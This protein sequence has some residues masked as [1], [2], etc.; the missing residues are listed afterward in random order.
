MVEEQQQVNRNQQPIR[1]RLSSS[2]LRWRL[3]GTS[4][5]PCRPRDNSR[6]LLHSL[7]N[8]PRLHHSP[9]TFSTSWLEDSL[10]LSLDLFHHRLALLLQ[11]LLLQHLLLLRE[12]Q[13]ALLLQVGRKEAPP[14]HPLQEAAGPPSCSPPFPSSPISP[15]P[16]HLLTSLVSPTLSSASWRA[17]SGVTLRPGSSASETS[18]SCWTRP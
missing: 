13:L 16:Y 3:S 4:W 1:Q 2:R 14:P 11:H 15:L 9:P 12:L 7:N 6:H 17:R 5:R 18:R 10:E 8:R